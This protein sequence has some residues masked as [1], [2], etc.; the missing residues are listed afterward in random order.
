MNI[1]KIIGIVLLLVGLGLRLATDA[2]TVGFVIGAAGALTLLAG[3]L[4]SRKKAP[5]Q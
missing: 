1:V 2:K 3:A 4:M 5:T